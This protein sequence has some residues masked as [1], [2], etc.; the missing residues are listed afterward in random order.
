MSGNERPL[1]FGTIVVVGGGCYGSYYVRQLRRAHTAGA[2]AWSRVLVVD[3]DAACALVKNGSASAEETSSDG[4]IVVIDEWR[5]FFKRY[6]DEASAHREAVGQDAIVPSPLMPHLMFEW[7]L[8][9]ARERWPERQID[10]QPLE[11]TPEVPWQRATPNG[12]H[13]VSFAEWICPINCIEPATCP[14]TRST[15]TWSLPDTARDYAAEERERGRAL[16][17]PVIF[18][19]THRAYGVGMFDTREVVAG[20]DLIRSVAEKSAAEILVG[21]MSH[22]HGAF[23]RLVIGPPTGSQSGTEG[24]ATRFREQ[25]A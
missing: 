24:A 25:A 7:L 14:H 18:H 11:R 10:T 1:R 2:V 20:D 12:P 8:A 15:R 4:V 9:R 23:E 17:G 16:A 21:T 6:L 19:C 5:S 13:Y 22:C 3:R